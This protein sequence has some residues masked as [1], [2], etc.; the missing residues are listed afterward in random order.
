[1]FRRRTRRCLRTVAR[2][3][4]AYFETFVTAEHNHLPPDNFQETPHPVVAP[5]NLADQYRRLSAVDRFGAR[6]RLDQPGRCGRSA[7][8]RRWRP[9]RRWSAIAA[10]SSTG[11]RR[12]RSGRSIRSMC[13]ASTAAISPAIWSR[14]PRPAPN[15]RKRRR[16]ICRAISTAFSTAS[17]SSTRAWPNCLTTAGSSGRCG[18]GCSTGSSACAAPSRRSR[19]SPKWRRSAPST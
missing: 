9:S 8:T 13:R 5:Q 1:M 6:F 12:R 2:R 17:P 3:T 16:C 7:S 15:G 10:I 4:W 14:W 18:N 19:R 11:T